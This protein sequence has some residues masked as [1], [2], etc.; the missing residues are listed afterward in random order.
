MINDQRCE[1][2]WCEPV[3]VCLDSGADCHVLPLSFYSEELGTTN[4]RVTRTAYDDNRCP[5]KCHTDNR[6]KSRY[7]IRVSKGE[8]KN[9]ESHR[10][11][12]IWRSRATAVRSRKVVEN[13]L[14]YGTLQPRESFSGERKFKNSYKFPPKFNNDRSE[15]LSS[16]STTRASRISS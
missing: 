16:R 12:R 11:L 1:R 10:Q 15:N 2:D 5:R 7:Y 3:E 4:Y 9:F 6:D 8:R 14:G 13:W